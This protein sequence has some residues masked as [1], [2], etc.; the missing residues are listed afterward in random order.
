MLEQSYYKPFPG[1]DIEAHELHIEVESESD[2]NWGEPLLMVV[3][4][5]LYGTIVLVGNAVQFSQMHSE[6][7]APILTGTYSDGQMSFMPKQLKK[8]PARGFEKL[9]WKCNFKETATNVVA[10]LRACPELRDFKIDLLSHKPMDFIAT[11]NNILNLV[12][13]L[14]LQG[15]SI[16]ADH[17][18]CSPGRTLMDLEAAQQR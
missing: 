14:E 3:P 1:Q 10:D 16:P 2:G 17:F 15:R 4:V 18:F 8:A 12:R 9:I 7:L 6:A 11:D 13:Q 5:H